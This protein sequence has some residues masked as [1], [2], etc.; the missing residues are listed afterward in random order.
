MEFPDLHLAEIKF[1]AAPTKTQLT[2]LLRDI[3]KFLGNVGGALILDGSYTVAD[4]PL[5]QTLNSAIQLKAAADAFEN[6]P[7][8]S[9]L[10]VPQPGPQ[11][12]RGR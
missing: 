7:N 2:N 1:N 6:G 3:S 8:A 5:G 9:G 12:V 4:P 11:V 10:A